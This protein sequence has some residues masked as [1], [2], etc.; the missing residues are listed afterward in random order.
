MIKIRY[1]I[2]LVSLMVI[3]HGCQKDEIG[4]TNTTVIETGPIVTIESSVLGLVTDEA[5]NPMPEVTVQYKADFIKTDKYGYFN[6]KNASAAF[7]GGLLKFNQDGY[8]KNYKWFYP[9]LDDN[10]FVRV[11]MIEEK[12]V[13][14]ITAADGGLVTLNG[15]ATV[16]FPPSAFE[17]NQSELKI[18]GHWY[19]PSGDK[20]AEEMPG[21]LRGIDSEE[22]LVQLA[23]YGMVAVEIRDANGNDIQLKEGV[24]AK[25]EFPLSAELVEDASETIKTWSFDEDRA[26]WVEEGS[27]TLVD[28]KYVAEVSH[29]SFWNCDA[30]F[31]VV[32]IKGRLVDKDGNPLVGVKMCIT[33]LSRSLT[34]VGWTSYDGVFCGKIP[35]DAPLKFEAKDECGGF[36]YQGEIGPFSEDIDLGDIVA[37]ATNFV[38]VSGKLLCDGLPMT[39]AYALLFLANGTQFIAEPDDQ[40]LFVFTLPSC[41]VEKVSVKGINLDDYSET[42]WAIFT[43]FG[44]ELYAGDIELCDGTTTLADEY[45]DW[46]ITGPAQEYKAYIPEAEATL[47]NNVLTLT[48]KQGGQQKPE[49]TLL[50]NNPFQGPDNQ[51]KNINTVIYEGQGFLY[52]WCQEGNATDDCS[53]ILV[54]LTLY[55]GTEGSYIEGTFMGTVHGEVNPQ[56]DVMGSFRVKLDEVLTYSTVSGV[57]WE[58]A[59]NNGIRDAGETIPD[60]SSI[61]VTL[62][63]QGNWIANTVTDSEGKYSIDAPDNATYVIS[64][65]KPDGYRY[66]LQDVGN[67]DTDSDADSN[68]FTEEFTPDGITDYK[69]DVG[70]F[71]DDNIG[72]DLRTINPSCG[73][74]NGSYTVY[75]QSQD[76]LFIDYILETKLDGNEISSIPYSPWDRVSD[77]GA[78]DYT[79]TIY[80]P[81]GDVACTG[82][83]TLVDTDLQ[84][85]PAAEL[86]C[87]G[88]G[89]E[90]YI[91]Y[92]CQPYDPNSNYTL[93][94]DNGEVGDQ[95]TISSPGVYVVTITDGNGCSGEFDVDLTEVPESSIGGTVWVDSA[96]GNP[97]IFDRTYEETLSGVAVYLYDVNGVLL[98]NT[99]SDNLG[100]FYFYG[101]ELGEEYIIGLDVPTN[102][103]LVAIADPSDPDF[104]SD[105]AIDPTT[106][107][108]DPIEVQECGQSFTRLIGL[109]PK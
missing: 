11:I 69:Y 92:E 72:C 81:Q 31:P 67:D 50:I 102:Y 58:D 59:D 104:K 4:V 60:N 28:N 57:Y 34:R 79:Y 90:A 99:N 68:G 86:E 26:Y 10:A 8:F 62:L 40:G 66:T 87:I 82:D 20:L 46:K 41:A 39:N 27:A 94:W 100:Q 19:D 84:C 37:D 49:I 32:H 71:F 2:L 76:S 101:L 64:F 74:A 6:V 3:S 85:A 73:L 75:A 61:T 25:V 63:S 36:I 103:D 21:D 35:K 22:A 43:D 95:I 107:L 33:D 9:Q 93:V 7:H 48:S 23:T 52:G 55:E 47:V 106:G 77:L 14:T 54:N 53:E 45:F 5:G 97:S 70:V 109:Q 78:G 108:S 98:Q 44:A 56:N 89:Y 13:G 24:T 17:S 29:F 65:W 16:T 91:Y 83:F 15:G 38:T 80:D 30:P 42:D 1:F 12:E 18:Y 88:N 105:S 96:L 51:V